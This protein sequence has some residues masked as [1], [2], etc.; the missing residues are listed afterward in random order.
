MYEIVGIQS[1]DIYAQ[2]TKPEC[3]RAINDG[4]PYTAHDTNTS[5]WT[6]NPRRADA[7]FEEPLRVIR[8]GNNES[9]CRY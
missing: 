3:M 6:V 7:V 8:R 1:G 4:H 5:F 9:L 2:G